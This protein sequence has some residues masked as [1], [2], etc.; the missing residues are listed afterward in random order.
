MA[1]I[2]VRLVLAVTSV[3]LNLLWIIALVFLLIWL[4][5]RLG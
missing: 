1:W 2:V 3:F 4:V 5:K